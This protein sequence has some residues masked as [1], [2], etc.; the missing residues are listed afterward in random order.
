M[1]GHAQALG[2]IGDGFAFLG[3]LLYETRGDSKGYLCTMEFERR[4]ASSSYQH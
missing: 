3:H 4:Y 1:Y 2:D